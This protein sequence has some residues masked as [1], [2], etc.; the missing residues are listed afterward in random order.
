MKISPINTN[1]VQTKQ[2]Q[3]KKQ[4]FK[5][6]NATPETARIMKCVIGNHI[7]FSSVSKAIEKEFGEFLN[8][9]QIQSIKKLN[10]IDNYF[11]TGSEIRNIKTEHKANMFEHLLKVISQAQPI[12]IYKI[13]GQNSFIKN[14]KTE[15]ELN[16]VIQNIENSLAYHP[17]N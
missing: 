8:K 2:N 9:E 10:L 17:N 5:A 13:I 4:S 12:T 1:C 16:Q 14:A 6:F 11:M 3:Q 15:N 7:K